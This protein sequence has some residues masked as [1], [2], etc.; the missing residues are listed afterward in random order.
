MTVLIIIVGSGEDASVQVQ[1]ADLYQ[2]LE[3][4]QAELS[5]LPD[6]CDVDVFV[7][8]SPAAPQESLT[9]GA[10]LIQLLSVLGLEVVFDTYSD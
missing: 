3:G 6:G 4:H 5:G 2:F 8:W 9:L 1:L 7:G 10:G